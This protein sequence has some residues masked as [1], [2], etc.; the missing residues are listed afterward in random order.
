MSTNQAFAEAATRAGVAVQTALRALRVPGMPEWHDEVYRA[1]E[2]DAAKVPWADEQANPALVSW[3]NAEAPGRVR[4]GAR[5]IVVGCGLGD[6]VV[7]LQ[8]RGYDASGFD[9]SPTAIDWAR[10]RFPDQAEAF[11]VTDLFE[12]PSRLRRRFDLV[13]EAY[14]IQAV[15]LDRRDAAVS[16]IAS[17]CCPRGTVVCVCRGRDDDHPLDGFKGPPWPLSKRELIDL[18]EKAG[19]HPVREPDDFE[20]DE[21]PPVRRLRAAFVHR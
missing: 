18:F 9:V 17:L 8:N 21:T 15:P 12:P 10:H 11:M 19:M 16:A 20:D 5:A 14:T 2:H 1:A 3:L 6:D 13:V 4:P 7:E